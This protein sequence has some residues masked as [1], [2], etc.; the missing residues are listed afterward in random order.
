MAIIRPNILKDAVARQK[1]AQGV[2]LLKNEFTTST[3]Q[4]LGIPGPSNPISTYDLFVVWHQV[5]M[6]TMTPTSQNERNAA[7]SGPVFPA[8]HRFML[9]QLEL[10]LQRALQDPAFGLPYWDWA[11][12][13]DLTP[14]KQKKSKIWAAD[15]MGNTGSP[16]SKGPFVFKASNPQSFRVR[17]DADSSNQLRQVNRGLRRAIG[18][19]AT[20]LPRRSDT[21]TALKTTPYDLPPWDRSSGGFRNFLEGWAQNPVVMHNRVHVWVGGDMLP[22]TSPNDP[23]F[24]L[25]HCN[26][27]RIWEAWMNK[28]GRTYVPLDNASIDL[29]GHRLHDDLSSLI[30]PPTQPAAVLNMTATYTY[31]TLLV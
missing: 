19:G 3:T 20:T 24:F 12:D 4:S 8:W 17:I 1:Y 30:S 6:M 10:N 14:S 11:A 18:A 16:I 7:H 28:N 5:A 22:P 31:D 13:G 21:S 26:V 29:K 15:C 27:D 23:V 25:N 2:N 9:R